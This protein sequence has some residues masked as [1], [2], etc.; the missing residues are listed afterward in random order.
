[1]KLVMSD[2]DDTIKNDYQD[3]VIDFYNSFFDGDDVL[4]DWR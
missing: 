4:V 2:D 3:V 1:M